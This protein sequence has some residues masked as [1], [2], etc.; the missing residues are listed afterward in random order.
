MERIAYQEVPN[1]MFEQLR[2][3]EDYLANSTLDMSLMELIRLRMSQM[4]K[5]AYC[6][7]MHY[8]ELKHLGETELRLSALCIWK[9]TPFFSAKERAVLQFTEELTNMAR[10]E[11][12][13]ATY[14]GLLPYFD[15]TEISYLSLVIGQ[16]NTWNT[17]MKVFRF[18]PGNYKVS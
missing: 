4:N 12:S 7:D 11:L 9:E 18:Q 6:V 10:V 17:L 16:I 3:I 1:G 15:K 8:K 2:K 13:D 5:C 14:E